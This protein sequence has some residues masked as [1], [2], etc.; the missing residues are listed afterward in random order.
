MATE[1]IY[2]I[3]NRGVERREIFTDKWEYRRALDTMSYYRFLS[4]IRYSKYIT[5]DKIDVF[6][7]STHF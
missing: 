5:L 7:Y 6:N 4:L 1:E 2:H 3:F